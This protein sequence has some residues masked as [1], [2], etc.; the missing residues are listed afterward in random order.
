M[1]KLSKAVVILLILCLFCLAGCGSSGGEVVIDG[2]SVIIT[3]SSDVLEITGETTLLEYMEVL[4]ENGEITFEEY[5][6]MIT[7]INGIEPS[8]LDSEF[9]GLYTNDS[10]LSNSAWGEFEYDGTAY[11]SAIYGAGSLVIVEG[12]TYIWTVVTF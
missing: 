3:V 12:Y 5:E 6:G 7:A 1:K 11:A 10:D 8:Y 4:Q 2:D 9:W